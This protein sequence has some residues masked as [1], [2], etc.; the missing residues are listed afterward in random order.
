MTKFIERAVNLTIGAAL[1]MFKHKFFCRPLFQKCFLIGL[2][3]YTNFAQMSYSS[4]KNH[5]ELESSTVH[6]RTDESTFK[7][8]SIIIS[9][10]IDIQ[11]SDD[12]LDIGCGEGSI[13]YYL[14]QNCHTLSGFDFSESK[15]DAA[16]KKN[17]ECRYEIHSF[18][19]KYPKYKANKLFSYGVAQYCNPADLKTFIQQQVECIFDNKTQIKRED[20]MQDY[21]IAILDIPDKSKA[22]EYYKY[23]YKL[24]SLTLENCDSLLD[25]FNAIYTDGS[26]WQD[27]KMMEHIVLSFGLSSEIIDSNCSY[28]SHLIIRFQRNT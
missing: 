26:Y 8:M 13:D 21:L 23:H 15:I 5:W 10:A 3:H 12:I 28:R 27:L 22:F 16:R 19:D 17:P 24:S 2:I 20:D 9:D 7:N 18:L 1:H 14:K 4:A 25:K 11:P 6:T